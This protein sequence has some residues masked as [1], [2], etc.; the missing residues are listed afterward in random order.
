MFSVCRIS[1]II[2]SI[3]YPVFEN[4]SLNSDNGAAVSQSHT[5][6]TYLFGSYKCIILF[7]QQSDFVTFM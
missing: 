7:L 1:E 2:I 5:G 4:R 6:I 3:F